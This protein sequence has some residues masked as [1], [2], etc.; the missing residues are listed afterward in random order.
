MRRVSFTALPV[1]A[2]LLQLAGAA[3]AQSTSERGASILIFPKVIADGSADTVLQLTNVFG[4][5]V[6]VFCSYVDGGAGWANASFSLTLEPQQPLSWVASHGR[7]ASSEAT[8]DAVP[9][10]PAG[11][12]GELLC[13]EVDIGGAPSGDDRLVGHATVVTLPD[14]DVAGYAAVGLRGAGFN[15]GD[16]VLCIGGERSDSCFTGAEYDACPALWFVSHPTDGAPDAQLGDGATLATRLAIAPCSQNVRDAQPAALRIVFSVTNAFEQRFT[17]SADVTCWA[18]LGL[19]DV[20]DGA[21]TQNVL[22]SDYATTTL[23]S[24]TDQGG[25][26]LVAEVERH[27]AAGPVVSRAAVNPHHA[28]VN[29]TSDFIILPMGRR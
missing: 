10:A 24:D 20:G 14:G 29:Q 19:A 3:A 23:G 25:F 13:V 7:D 1:L 16:E 21:F 9:A 2:C 4:S 6:S 27:A 26:A 28:G 18:D 8:R 22:G 15:D 11:L 5:R 17:T 12:R